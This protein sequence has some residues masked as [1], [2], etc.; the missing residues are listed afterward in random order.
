MEDKFPFTPE[1]QE[2]FI[3]FTIHD[4]SGVKAMKL[5][6][7]SY[8]TLLEHAVTFALLEEM[9][10]KL[11]RI[12]GETVLI[13]ESRTFFKGRDYRESLLQEDRDNIVKLIRKL[14]KAPAK[15]GD[16]LLKQMAKFKS[17]VKL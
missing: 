17:F 7:N 3:R 9:V 14:Y 4:K 16:I 8:F 15:D 12:P 1:M 6:H 13:E 10:K 2:E 11:S 5:L